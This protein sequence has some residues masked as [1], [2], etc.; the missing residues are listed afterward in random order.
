MTRFL[1]T[2]TVNSGGYEN[3]SH[4]LIE[5][6]TLEE[7]ESLFGRVKAI[8]EAGDSFYY[9]HDHLCESFDSHSLKPITEAEAATLESLLSLSVLTLAE[10]EALEAGESE[11]NNSDDDDDE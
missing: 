7:A 4:S 3:T 11:F 9:L 10:V 5:A 2:Y 6:E 1:L 8:D